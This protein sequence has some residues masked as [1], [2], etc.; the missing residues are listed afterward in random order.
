MPDGIR[1]SIVVIGDEILGGFVADTNSGWLAS[2]LQTLGFPLDRVSTVPDSFD[3]ISE[4]LQTELGRARPRLILTSGG[5]GS[6]PDD[7]TFEAVARHLGIG[8]RIEPL[9]DDRITAA[10]AWTSSQG[11]DV[12]PE[13]ERSM[14]KMSLVPESARV[15]LGSD[16]FLPGVAVDIDGGCGTQ[17][18]AT[19]VVMPGV[20]AE[21]RRIFDQG[22]VAQILLDKGVPQHVE[23]LQHPYPESILNPVLDRLVA[24]FPDVHLGSYPGRDCTVRLKGPRD[25]VEAA[26]ALVR[27]Y[28]GELAEDPGAAKLSAAW[29]ARWAEPAP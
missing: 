1:V 4:A 24:E 27:G 14:R 29:Q 19:I 15:L 2:R 16:G 11:V 20:P 12:T 7:L 26:M 23:E 3:A 22:V 10:L 5:I 21:L 28:L 13:H 25:R 8:L 17:Q 6:T 9:I 18:G